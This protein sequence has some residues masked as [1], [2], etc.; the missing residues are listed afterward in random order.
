LKLA[1]EEAFRLIE[2]D[3]GLRKPENANVKRELLKRYSESINLARI[4]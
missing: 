2:T 4:G 3:P 1:R